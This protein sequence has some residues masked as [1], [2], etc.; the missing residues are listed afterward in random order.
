MSAGRCTEAAAENRSTT[1]EVKEI[2]SRVRA[3]VVRV[4]AQERV[5]RMRTRAPPA[6]P[7]REFPCCSTKCAATPLAK[8]AAGDVLAM[9]Q[10]L[11]PQHDVRGG[12][13]L[14]RLEVQVVHEDSGCRRARLDASQLGFEFNDE[15]DGERLVRLALVGRVHESELFVWVRD[16]HHSKHVCGVA[17]LS[18]ADGDAGKA[19]NSSKALESCGFASCA[20]HT[21]MFSA[22]LRA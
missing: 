11:L 22:S 13:L 17:V 8:S 7:L 21:H 5:L 10:S 2:R 18:V 9:N 4:L 3:P 20:S 16:R 19:R 1:S 12:E 6:P 15:I 14:R